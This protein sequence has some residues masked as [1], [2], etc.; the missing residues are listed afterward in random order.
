MK[1]FDSHPISTSNE[2]HRSLLFFLFILL[3]KN[4]YVQHPIKC[5]P[6]T[7]INK[8]SLYTFDKWTFK[9]DRPFDVMITPTR[10]ISRA[11]HER[12]ND[13]DDGWCFQIFL[14]KPQ[15]ERAN[16]ARKG[17]N[18]YYFSCWCG[19]GDGAVCCRC[20]CFFTFHRKDAV[21]HWKRR[22]NNIVFSFWL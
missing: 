8:S 18:Y 5:R 19:G 17:I 9:I 3:N 21:E 12:R 4:E 7:L 1:P 2:H 22:H 14:K 13:D 20:C 16:W 15:Q 11:E 6:S 10:N